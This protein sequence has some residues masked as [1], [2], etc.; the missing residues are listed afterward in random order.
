[1]LQ[2]DLHSLFK[3]PSDLPTKII[4]FSPHHQNTRLI[5]TLNFIFQRVWQKNYILTN[6]FDEFILSDKLK[7]NYSE[8]Y[9]ENCIN[10]YP[11]PLITHYLKTSF[12]PNFQITQHAFYEEDI[13]AKAFFFLSRYEEWFFQY[14]PDNHQRFEIHCSIFREQ[15]KTPLVDESIHNFKQYI[16][17]LY[18]QFKTP[19]FFQPIYTFDLDN[20]L[21]FKGKSLLRTT[22]AFLKHLLKQEYHLIDKR[23]K[24]LFFKQDDPFIEVYKFIKQLSQKHP[25]IF[26]ILCESN[27][28]FDRAANIQHPHSISTLKYLHSFAH[29]GLHPSYDTFS[30]KKK[31]LNEKNKLEKILE[32]S[33]I[34]SRQHYLR[35]KISTTPKL[36][37]KSGIQY[38]F[39]MGFASQTAYRAGT[40]YPFYFY[41]F[42]TET[43]SNLLFIPFQVMDGAYFNYQKINIEDSIQDLQ[44][45][46]TTVQKLGGYFIP[47]FHEITL[48]PLFNKNALKWQ[49][50]LQ[51]I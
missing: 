15:L 35:M 5:Y 22:G 49:S 27:A 30:D 17:K 44:N 10:V 24:T 2:S 29:I 4:V 13:F 25:V 31:L 39:S 20:I 1:M 38:D 7:I 19:Y 43:T 26:F 46:Y 51:A 41:D 21:A 12:I 42:E 48:S 18:P 16:L 6:N 11:T 45:I 14:Q 33:I 36:L 50:I 8:N 3:L 40:S 9:I 37:I 32:T 34:A 28:Q 23:I 47:L